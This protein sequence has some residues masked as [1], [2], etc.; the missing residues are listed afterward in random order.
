VVDSKAAIR[1]VDV[2]LSANDPSYQ[3]TYP[4]DADYYITLIKELHAALRRPLQ[5]TWVK[6]HQDDKQPYDKLSRDAQL[7][8]DADRLAT[9]QL[10]ARHTR[11]IRT[12]DHQ[13]NL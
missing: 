13:P 2:L 7:N 1:R 3:A 12:I 10:Q 6:G 5:V 9:A 11:P 8:V 4:K